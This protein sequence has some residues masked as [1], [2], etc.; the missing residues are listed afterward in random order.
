MTGITLANV[1]FWAGVV[2]VLA[3]WTAWFIV[4]RYALWADLLYAAGILL[5]ALAV[6]IQHMYVYVPI[7]LAVCAFFTWSWWSRMGARHAKHH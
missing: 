3:A 6:A 2:L 1:M 4:K 5:W 7:C